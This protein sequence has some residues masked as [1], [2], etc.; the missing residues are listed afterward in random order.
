MWLQL[1][2][3]VIACVRQRRQQNVQQNHCWVCVCAYKGS[4]WAAAPVAYPDL[5]ITASFELSSYYYS[6]KSIE[7][8]RRATVRL[9]Y[10]MG[11]SVHSQIQ[12]SIECIE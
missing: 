2:H 10:Y 12:Q 5:S 3:W 11:H 9:F 4:L 7:C 8:T 1:T 6:S